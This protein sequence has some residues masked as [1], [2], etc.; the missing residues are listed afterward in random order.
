GNEALFDKLAETDGDDYAAYPGF[1]ELFADLGTVLTKQDVRFLL[2]MEVRRKVQDARGSA[3]PMGDFQS[4]LQLQKAIAENMKALGD[5][6]EPDPSYA[7]TFD[8]PTEP[9]APPALLARAEDLR[10]ALDLVRVH[11]SDGLNEQ[12]LKTLRELLESASGQN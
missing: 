6:N 3:F 4:D 1:D 11:E 2:R 10:K 5:G 12:Q 9:G 8:E 7:K